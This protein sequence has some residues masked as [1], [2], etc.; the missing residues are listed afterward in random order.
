MIYKKHKSSSSRKRKHDSIDRCIVNALQL[1]EE[2]DQ[3]VC[4]VQ[5]PTS[6]VKELTEIFHCE[7]PDVKFSMSLVSSLPSP[8]PV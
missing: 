3:I 4:L 2:P 7:F 1:M 6:R 5:S 8:E